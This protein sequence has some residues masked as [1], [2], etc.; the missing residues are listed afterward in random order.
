MILG[1]QVRIRQVQLCGG[2]CIY[3]CR[4]TTYG[5]LT[6]A[7]ISRGLLADLE[8]FERE[9]WPDAVADKV[10]AEFLEHLLTS[11][12]SLEER[13]AYWK[14]MAGTEALL[15]YGISQRTV[16]RAASVAQGT[17][18]GWKKAARE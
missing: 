8:A 17:A 12:A 15:T 9:A 14:Q 1:W 6:P 13:L 3:A 7:G 5:K 16:A 11:I 2:V 18:S 4:M 10:P